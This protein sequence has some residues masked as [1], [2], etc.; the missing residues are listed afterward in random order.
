MRGSLNRRADGRRLFVLRLSEE[1]SFEMLQEDI[2]KALVSSLSAPSEDIAREI[3]Q[4]AAAA[5]RT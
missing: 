1:G 2:K 3:M 4:M 5:V